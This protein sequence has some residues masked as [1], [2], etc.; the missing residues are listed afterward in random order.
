[1][2][3]L[4][5]WQRFLPVLILLVVT[6]GVLQARSRV[7]V[8]PPHESLDA[9]PMVL[10]SWHGISLPLNQDELDT[11]GPG[12][13]LLR[14]YQRIAEPS[15]NLFIAFFP[16]Q[17][18]GDTIHSPQNCLPGAGWTPVERSHLAL[19]ADDGSVISVNRYLIAKGL[20]RQLVFY[21]YLSNGRV[22]PSEYWAKI[23]LVDD[24][25]RLNRTDGAMIRV[26]TPIAG[27]GSQAESQ[28]QDRALAFA[29]RV[30]P[31]LDT[32]IPR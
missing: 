11:L 16:S 15:V 10:G 18:T 23:Y 4:S 8:L 14:D 31:M 30:V 17:R 24:A 5:S 19:T 27:S 32:Y 3:Q 9:F 12:E 28:A 22:T 29:R 21:W 25:I 2:R 13:F 7:E 20:D 6:A 1:M 26:V